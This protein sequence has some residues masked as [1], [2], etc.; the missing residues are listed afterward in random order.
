M[1][2]DTMQF[3]NGAIPLVMGFRKEK[4]F[5]KITHAMD[6][7]GHRFSYSQGILKD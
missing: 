6:N 3:A 7:D 1:Q 2:L 5:R 4:Q